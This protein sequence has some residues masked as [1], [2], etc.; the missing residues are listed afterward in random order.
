MLASLAMV[1]APVIVFA[2]PVV[3]LRA[4]AGFLDV[5][6][7]RIAYSEDDP[8]F[9]YGRDGGQDILF[10][11]LRL[12]AEFHAADRHTAIFLYQP[13]ALE[14]R[15]EMPPDFSLDGETFSGSTLRVL[16]GF[17]FYRVSYLNTVVDRS[18]FELAAGGSLQIRNANTEFEA[19]GG[20][21][22]QPAEGFYRSAN[23]GPV[24]LLKVR[25][26]YALGRGFWLATEIDGIYAPISY[27]NGSDNDTTGALLDA[28]MRAG[29]TV[30][31]KVEVF[32]NAR[33]LGGGA[34][35][36]DPGNYSFNWLN[37]TT[38]SLGTSLA[39]Q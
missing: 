36:S 18:R 14:T 26:R 24:P 11:F 35:N 37:V 20:R 8:A 13:L 21:N 34:T 9:R 38:V 25:A 3:S 28:S 19:R 32:A 5:V 10:P 39:L 30:S 6:D 22:G 16:Y 27:L 4:E 23:V 7:H 1:A 12:S 2:E 15:V 31:P 29:Y 17:P 33:Y